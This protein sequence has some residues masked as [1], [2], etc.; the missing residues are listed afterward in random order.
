MKDYHM[1][2]FARELFFIFIFLSI[3]AQLSCTKNTFIETSSKKPIELKIN[4]NKVLSGVDFFKLVDDFEF[5]KL[6]SSSVNLGAI[7][8]IEVLN[9][10]MLVVADQNYAHLFSKNGEHIRTLNTKGRGPNELSDVS[11]IAVCLETNKVYVKDYSK[12]LLVFNEIG[13][14]KKSKRFNFL[15]DEICLHNQEYIVLKNRSHNDIGSIIVYNQLKSSI[16]FKAIKLNRSEVFSTSIRSLF[17]NH[18]GEVLYMTPFR[19]TIYSI[20]SDGVFAKYVIKM[21][22]N[23]RNSE[24]LRQAQNETEI[25]EFDIKNKIPNFYGF[26][27]EDERFLAFNFATFW[28]SGSIHVVYDI[29]NGKPVLFD[30]LKFGDSDVHATNLFWN[31]SRVDGRWVGF[32]YPND[33]LN[34][35]DLVQDVSK[36]FGVFQCLDQLKKSTRLTD[37]PIVVV[38]SLKQFEN[39][40][41]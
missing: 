17:K 31:I 32:V 29:V 30:F 2:R 24:L 14:V 1:K 13:E 38:Y 35:K 7:Q 18:N 27:I 36:D 3:L 37:N 15:S 12:L 40:C 4:P 8:S 16:A 34:N 28:N 22:G 6:G 5:I 41:L 23:V 21:K 19:D 33:L 10:S 9:D 20:L 11:S 26:P 39:H 25:I